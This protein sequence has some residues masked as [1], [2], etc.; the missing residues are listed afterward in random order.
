MINAMTHQVPEFLI[1][2]IVVARQKNCIFDY[3]SCLLHFVK[4]KIDII[5]LL[6]IIYPFYS[7]HKLEYKSSTK[8]SN[9]I[10]PI[11]HHLISYLISFPYFWHC[12]INTH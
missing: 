6:I 12:V 8:F 10:I 11:Q 5:Q 4:R 9:I 7:K 1:I 3:S 2:E